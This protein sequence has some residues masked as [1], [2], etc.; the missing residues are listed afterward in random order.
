VN[1]PSITY[2]QH[3]RKKYNFN[4]IIFYNILIMEFFCTFLVISYDNMFYFCYII[5]KNN[6]IANIKY[7]PIHFLDSERSERMCWFY[8]D[9]FFSVYQQ[10]FG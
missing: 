1:I 3:Y 4:V 9:E 8:N 5:G 7:I 2:L 10:H 6:I